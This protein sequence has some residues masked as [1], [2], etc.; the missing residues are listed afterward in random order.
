MT[1]PAGEHHARRRRRTFPEQPP[2][3]SRTPEGTA[4]LIGLPAH[5]RGSIGETVWM[6]GA[7]VAVVSF[8]LGVADGVSMAA[9]QWI[10]ALRELGCRVRTVAGTGAADVLVPG[11]GAEDRHP[12]CPS[13][14][15]AACADA[16]V[17]IV[18][19]SAHCR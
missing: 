11:L 12:P 1:R 19:N 14:L 16:D 9:A 4:A 10:T 13:Q 17:V 8:R 3:P 7:R 6:Q 5:A 18:E 2:T 15:T